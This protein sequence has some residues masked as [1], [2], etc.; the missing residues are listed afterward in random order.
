MMM[1][2]LPIW[3]Q[4]LQEWFEDVGLVGVGYEYTV[5][6]LVLCCNCN[7]KLL[8]VEKMWLRK[9][10]VSRRKRKIIGMLCTHLMLEKGV[11]RK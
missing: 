8:E 6:G 3:T 4:H 5:V 1:M 7:E 9:K 2:V 11:K 10:R